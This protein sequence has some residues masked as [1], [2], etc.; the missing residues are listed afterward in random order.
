ML[1]VVQTIETD[2]GF[3]PLPRIRKM[4]LDITPLRPCVGEATH[5]KT[6]KSATLSGSNARDGT[7]Q[8]MLGLL[9]VSEPPVNHPAIGFFPYTLWVCPL[10]RSGFSPS[11]LRFGGRRWWQLR[12]SPVSTTQAQGIPPSS[13]PC[14]GP[15]QPASRISWLP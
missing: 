5:S 9:Y 15:V 3:L 11:I 12:T 8:G 1:I 10:C 13:P 7:V 6:S 14:L 2:Q 4:N